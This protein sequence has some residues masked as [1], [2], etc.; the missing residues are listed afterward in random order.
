MSPEHNS[1]PP[2][3]RPRTRRWLFVAGVLHCAGMLLV[4][5][6]LVRLT[7]LTLTF[8]L[9]GGGLLLAAACGIYVITV[10]YDLRRRRIL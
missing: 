3:A 2:A 6:A 7:P 10:A 9:G 8:S 1:A 4:M 5:S